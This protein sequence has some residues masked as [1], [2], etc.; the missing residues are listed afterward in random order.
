LWDAATGKE[1]RQW[2]PAEGAVRRHPTDEPMRAGRVLF[3]PDGKLLAAWRHDEHVQVWDAATGKHQWLFPGNN[4]AFSPDGKGMA[5][6][7]RGTTA[8]DANSGVIR[9]YDLA[10]GEVVRELRGVKS[11]IA[12]LVFSPDGRTLATTAQARFGLRIAG[13]QEEQD[14]NSVHLWDVASGQPRL[15]FAGP[16]H[17]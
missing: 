8:A 2:S 15:A 17:G 12:G 9:L 14:T 3:S 16:P 10:T 11:M 1:L 4:M 13:E 6:A 7:G 5:C